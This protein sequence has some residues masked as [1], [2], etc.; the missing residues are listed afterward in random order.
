MCLFN[1]EK[2]LKKDYELSMTICSQCPHE[3]RCSYYNVNTCKRFRDLKR[4]FKTLQK[5]Q[6]EDK[7]KQK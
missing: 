4:S 5:Y 7:D 1:T 3:Q 6:R 2:E